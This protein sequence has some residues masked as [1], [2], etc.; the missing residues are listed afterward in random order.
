MMHKKE[1]PRLEK[2]EKMIGDIDK[3]QTTSYYEYAKS[4]V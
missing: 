1:E 2:M 4:N 3:R